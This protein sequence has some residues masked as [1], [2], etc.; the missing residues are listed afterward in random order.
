[1]GHTGI[2]TA[3][4]EEQLTD[5]YARASTAETETVVLNFSDLEYMNSSGIGLIVT[6]LV[7]ANRHRQ[8]VRA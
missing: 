6:I 5:A 3:A 8:S 2:L 7:R 1:M 4:S